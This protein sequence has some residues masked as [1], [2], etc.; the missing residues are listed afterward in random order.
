MHADSVVCCQCRFD[1]LHM[2]PIVSTRSKQF[3]Q[4]VCCFLRPATPDTVVAQ[5]FA[6]PEEDLVKRKADRGSSLK[7]DMAV[8]L[9]KEPMFCFEASPRCNP[10]AITACSA[11]ASILAL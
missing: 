7:E 11:R 4:H 1:M 2:S 3:S 8:E 9:A 10:S 6:W 5:E